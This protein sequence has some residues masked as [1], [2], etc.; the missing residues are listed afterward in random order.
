MAE[1]TQQ[2]KTALVDRYVIEREL[3][4]G[5]MATVYLA[6]ELSLSLDASMAVCAVV[7]ESPDVHIVENF[8]AR[9]R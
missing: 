3:G 8:D 9:A 1:Q 7:D 6:R 5:G 4:A 2:L